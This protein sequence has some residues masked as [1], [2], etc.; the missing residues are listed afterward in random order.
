MFIKLEESSLN[1]IYEMENEESPQDLIKLHDFASL[2]QPELVPISS[3]VHKQKYQNTDRDDKVLTERDNGT[4]W[5][6][7]DDQLTNINS[8]TVCMSRVMPVP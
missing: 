1:Q 6:R 4:T 3:P 8:E 7:D 2:P 5:T